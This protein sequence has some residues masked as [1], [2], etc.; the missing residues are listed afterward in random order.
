MLQTRS[1]ICWKWSMFWKTCN[2]QNTWGCWACMGCNQQRLLFSLKNKITF[3]REEISE[4]WWD[5]GKYDRAADGTSNKGFCRGFEQWKRCWEN[6]V[7]SQ[8]TYFE[9]DWGIIVL[10]TM[11]LVSSS[12]KSLFLYYMAVYFVDRPCVYIYV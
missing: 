1:T 6:C 7:R 5:S 11:F 2:K 8:G 12:V 3:E 4:C 9:G 10:C